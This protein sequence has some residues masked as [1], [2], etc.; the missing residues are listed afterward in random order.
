MRD[1]LNA[2]LE[3]IGAESLTDEE[4]DSITLE[5]TEDQVANYNA[6]L[7]ILQ[8]RELVSDMASRLQHYFLAQGVSVSAPVSAVSNIFVGAVLCD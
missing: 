1:Y 4:F 5:D 2:I 8:A 6:L 7:V 3:F